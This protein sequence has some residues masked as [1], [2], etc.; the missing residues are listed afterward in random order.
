METEASIS[1]IGQEMPS[2]KQEIEE[3]VLEEL[4]YLARRMERVPASELCKHLDMS[5]RDI[6]YYVKQMRLHGY[7]DDVDKD[8]NIKISEIGRITGAQCRYRHETFIQFL[9]LI[10]VKDKTADV[11][12]CRMEHVVSEETVQQISNFVNYGDTFERVLKYADLQYRYKPG[13][14]SFLMGIYYQ[15]KRCPR[16]FAREFDFFSETIKLHVE[17]KASWFLLQPVQELPEDMELWYMERRENWIKADVINNCLRI[18]SNVFDYA[19]RSN[20]PLTEGS[21]LI[22]FAKEGEEPGEWQS[23]ELDVHIW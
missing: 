23:R 21:V 8:G 13:E 1:K 14:Y 18:P 5:K 17:D 15:E 12:A 2:S 19:M 10:G 20:D 6:N 9:Q 22:A 16:V 3:D 7:V 4:S 11:D